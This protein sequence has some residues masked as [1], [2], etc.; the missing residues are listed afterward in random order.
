[1]AK[2][3]SL[4]LPLLSVLSQCAG[5]GLSGGAGRSCEKCT[6]GGRGHVSA[7]STSSSV[8]TRTS[9]RPRPASLAPFF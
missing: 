4:S 8:M 7:S 5:L 3:F 9:V 1:M 2:L 6:C